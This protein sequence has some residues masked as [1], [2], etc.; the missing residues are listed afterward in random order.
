MPYLLFKGHA[1]KSKLLID[2]TS[3]MTLFVILM[4]YLIGKDAVGLALLLVDIGA[5]LLLSSV[6]FGHHIGILL[7]LGIKLLL[8]RLGHRLMTFFG[9]FEFDNGFISGGRDFL[10]TICTS[11]HLRLI[12]TFRKRGREAP[13]FLTDGNDLV[14]FEHWNRISGSEYQ[15]RTRRNNCVIKVMQ[16]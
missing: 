13:A 4:R 9:F 2:S 11:A 3:F 15:G 16:L 14:S 5:L 12:P 10:L 1:N 7:V 6:I 8:L